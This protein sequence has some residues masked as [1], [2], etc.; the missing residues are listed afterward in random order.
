MGGSIEVLKQYIIFENKIKKKFYFFN[1]INE[2]QI[3]QFK[4]K[5]KL[6]KTL[7]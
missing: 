7:L 6:D 1:D 3:I 2:K 5:E 4:K